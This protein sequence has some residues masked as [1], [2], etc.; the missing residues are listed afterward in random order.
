MGRRS[1]AMIPKSE[2]SLLKGSE[3][4]GNIIR[5]AANTIL[6]CG[7]W[8]GKF[9]KNESQGRVYI[10]LESSPSFLIYKIYFPI[11]FKSTED[12]KEL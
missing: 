8:M 9:Q 11:N 7:I 5:Y 6:F 12:R 2:Y 1:K 4:Y 10:S 3:N